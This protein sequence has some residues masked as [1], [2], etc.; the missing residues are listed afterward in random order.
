MQISNMGVYDKQAFPPCEPDYRS[1]IECLAVAS[2]KILSEVCTCIPFLVPYHRFISPAG[3]QLFQMRQKRDGWRYCTMQDY[4]NCSAK[5]YTEWMNEIHSAAFCTPCV[6]LKNTYLVTSKGDL[7]RYLN[8]STS[9]KRAVIEFTCND[10][11]Y[12]Y[13]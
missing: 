8:C 6:D 1:K 4:K 13:Y 3:K 2:I 10:K 5:A 11:F 7:G 9:D 12:T